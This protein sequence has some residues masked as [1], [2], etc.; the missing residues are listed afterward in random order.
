MAPPADE[1]GNTKNES[2]LT[3]FCEETYA[4]F[5]TNKVVRILCIPLFIT[6]ITLAVLGASK[7]EVRFSTEFFVADDDPLR[8]VFAIREKYFATFG[9]PMT[10][11]TYDIDHS[12]LEN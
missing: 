4:K 8:E 1:N 9:S 2:I 10:I 3:K 12:T 6:L 7:L 11:Y 5:I